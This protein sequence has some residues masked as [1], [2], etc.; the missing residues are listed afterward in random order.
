MTMTWAAWLVVERSNI[1]E[2]KPAPEGLGGKLVFKHAEAQRRPAEVVMEVG[3]ETG[4]RPAAR[5]LAAR[6]EG[7]IEEVDGR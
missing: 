4:E 2:A 3:S 6:D 1:L 5:A 7:G